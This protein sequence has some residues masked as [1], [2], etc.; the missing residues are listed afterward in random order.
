MCCRALVLPTL[1][2]ANS[3][4][5]LVFDGEFQHILRILNTNVD[6]TQN[7]V[8]AMTA[9]RGIGPRFST[10]ICKKADIDLNKR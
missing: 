2:I 6:G 10:L 3:Q 4:G 8:Y 5:S 7:V 9:I 1:D